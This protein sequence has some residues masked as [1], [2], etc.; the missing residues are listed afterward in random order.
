M[1]HSK[2]WAATLLRELPGDPEALLVPG[3]P[4]VSRNYADPTFLPLFFEWL[5][6]EIFQDPQEGLRW[7]KVVPE[8]ALMVSME[9][10]TRQAYHENLTKAYAILGGAF[11]ATNQYDA[12]EEQYQTALRIAATKEISPEA[13]ADVDQRLSYLRV[14][15]DK[16]QEALELLDKVLLSYS[17]PCL[18]KW[19][20]LVRR[21]YALGRLRRF[22]E[23]VDC[24][25]VVLEKVNPKGSAAAKRAHHAAMHNMAYAVQQEKGGR[26]LLEGPG[27]CRQGQ[28]AHQATGPAIAQPPVG[29]GFDLGQSQNLWCKD[30]FFSR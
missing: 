16:P 21:G 1:P 6:Q 15:Q 8:L 18:G 19:E 20:A 22:S 28:E 2:T 25:G 24:F 11:R 3:Y 10:G 9:D 27:L 4:G 23:A 13:R 7:A 14:C 12:A 5:D 30:W 29:R 26:F 17:K